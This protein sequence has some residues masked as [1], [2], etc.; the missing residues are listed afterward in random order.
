MGSMAGVEGGVVGGGWG[1][2]GSLTQNGN[3]STG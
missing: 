3:R 1:V 2:G